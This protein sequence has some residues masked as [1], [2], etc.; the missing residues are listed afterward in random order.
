MILLD[1]LYF[2]PFWQISF[3]LSKQVD[4]LYL[5]GYVIYFSIHV[6]CHIFFKHFDPY[7]THCPLWSAT[8]N[9]YQLISFILF[10][11]L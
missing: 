3:F 11:S 8:D 1:L 5:L 4:C 9:A 6:T 10:S 2:V 7:W